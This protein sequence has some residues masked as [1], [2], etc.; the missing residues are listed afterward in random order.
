MQQQHEEHHGCIDAF[1][2]YAEKMGK[3]VVEK[4][5]DD[6]TVEDMRD[7]DCVV[8]LGGDH[9]FLR[10]QALIWNRQIPILGVNTNRKV[11]MGAL[12]P[13]FIDY[14]DS[15]EQAA[16]LLE[17]ME[18]D[19]ARSY[20][21]RTRILYKRIKNHEEEEEQKVLC[22]NEVFCAEKEVSSASRFC[23]MRDGRDLGVFKSSGLIISSGTGSTGWLYAARQLTADQI[24][25]ISN[26]IGSLS[27][28]CDTHDVL[29]EKISDETIF[30]RND[31]R[32]YFQVR[33]GFSN[34]QMSEGFCK[35]MKIT[36]EMLNG[37][38]VIDAWY[39]RSLAIGD[40]FTV[41]SAPEYV[42][43]AMELEI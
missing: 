23:I 27:S 7:V 38:V 4:S 19:Y 12:S 5:E 36:S 33:E 6:C 28:D 43:R 34:T 10:A 18:D 24:R 8:A 17:T 26:C 41:H 15:E 40:Q 32:M 21:K 16:L 13:H 42:L 20:E 25:D 31:P 29:A 1:R 14:K 39:N 22:L 37:Q 11:Y 35:H 9:T 2:A 3:E 30:A